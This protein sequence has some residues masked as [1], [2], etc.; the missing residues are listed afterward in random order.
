MFRFEVAGKTFSIQKVNLS[1]F[2]PKLIESVSH[3]A[4]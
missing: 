4:L 1:L 3:G 2:D